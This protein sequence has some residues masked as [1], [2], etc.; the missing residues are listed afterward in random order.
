MNAPKVDSSLKG[1]GHSMVNV[2]ELKNSIV[3]CDLDGTLIRVNSYKHWLVFSCFVALVSLRFGFLLDVLL[4]FNAKRKGRMTR[5]QVKQALI[6][7][8]NSTVPV[9]WACSHIFQKYLRIYVRSKVIER[10]RQLQHAGSRVYI[11]TAAWRGY[12][13]MFSGYYR[14]D[15][16]IATDTND[17]NENIGIYKLKSLLEKTIIEDNLILFTDHYDDL[18]LAKLAKVVYLVYPDDASLKR[19]QESGLDFILFGS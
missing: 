11:T 3:A 9:R 19:F 17:L 4:S 2:V 14:F 16:V 8:A 18:P 7:T 1:Y 12:C 15:G 10:V 5:W 6:Q 13:D